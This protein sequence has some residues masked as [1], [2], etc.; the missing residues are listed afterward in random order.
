VRAPP[1]SDYDEI[2]IGYAALRRPDPRIAAQIAEA[3]GPGTLLNLGAGAGS[4][5]PRRPGVVALE[6]S[7]TMLAQRAPDAA[8][9]VRGS[10]LRLPFADGRFDVA[11]AVLTLHHWRDPRRGLEEMARVSRRQVL[12]H[13]GREHESFWLVRDYLPEI[14]QVDADAPTLDE[15]RDVLGPL[16]VRPVP[17]PH[18]CSDGFLCAYWRRPHAY[19]DPQVRRAISSLA[20]LPDAGGRL[21]T[22]RR[23]LED[24]SWQRRFAPL[25]ERETMDYGYRLIV[26]SCG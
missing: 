5:E 15:I 3:V 12:L 19:L 17:I 26:A 25:L 14:A 22:L 24:G 21:E 13:F 8:P 10:V 16:D 6:L 20:A 1:R 2:G 11:L 23:D 9:A 4:Y 7:A 18:D